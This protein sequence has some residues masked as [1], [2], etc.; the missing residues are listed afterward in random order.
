M[1]FA[2]GA[3]TFTCFEA[4]TELGA[5]ELEVRPGEAGNDAP[6]GKTNIGAIDAMANAR[7]QLGDVLFAETRVRAGVARFRARVTC[8][9]ALNVN[10]V[11]RRWIYRMGFEH[12]FDVA[13]GDPPLIKSQPIRV[14]GG[15]FNSKR[16][17]GAI[18]R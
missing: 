1:F 13:H 15:F 17:A 14:A 2:F 10:G 9:D 3:A 8:G 7:D 6:G 4:G 16:R 5:R 11:I 12:L 18:A